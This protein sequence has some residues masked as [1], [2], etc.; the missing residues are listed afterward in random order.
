[1]EEILLIINTIA[2]SNFME[3]FNF[4]NDT[5]N[6]DIDKGIYRDIL[7]EWFLNRDLKVLDNYD[8]IKDTANVRKNIQRTLSQNLFDSE[9]KYKENR[10]ITL[11]DL[12]IN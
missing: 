11:L 10:I 7:S 9:N 3:K 5:R 6:M 4:I 1:M 8:M 12:L 2:K